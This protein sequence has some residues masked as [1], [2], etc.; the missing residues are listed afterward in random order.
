MVHLTINKCPVKMFVDSGCER[1]L[2]PWDMY[3]QDMGQLEEANV[4][5]RP[6]GTETILKCHGAVSS[7]IEA[8]S[9]C[10]QP[11]NVY[12]VEGHQAEPL[13]GRRDAL[14][15]G[16]ITFDKKGK[17]PEEQVKLVA[18]DLQS[19]GI[20]INANREATKKVDADEEQRIEQIVSKHEP[21]FSGIGLLKGEDVKFDIDP[22]IEPVA[23]AF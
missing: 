15:L 9:G 14:A 22:A 18:N 20:K 8:R 6:Y 17:R 4:Q 3:T 5:F 1:T 11:T 13:L 23:K 2:L 12:V 19:A 10:K 21:M 7:S 16:I